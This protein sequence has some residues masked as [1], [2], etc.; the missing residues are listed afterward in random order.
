[1]ARGTSILSV[2]RQLG[3]AIGTAAV[4]VPLG[5][6]IGS[7]GFAMAFTFAGI[8]TVIAVPVVALLRKGGRREALG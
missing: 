7:N 3:V 2:V 1:M 5:Q 8:V 6:A 4:A